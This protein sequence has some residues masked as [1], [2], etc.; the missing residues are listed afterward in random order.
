MEKYI[1]SGGYSEDGELIQVSGNVLLTAADFLTELLYSVKHQT[2]NSPLS[3]MEYH[4]KVLIPLFFPSMYNP[5]CLVQT[6]TDAYMCVH[7]NHADAH[8]DNLSL[9]WFKLIPRNFFA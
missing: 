7:R 5:L 4:F 3:W 1:P 2:F 6:R 8:T 9:Y